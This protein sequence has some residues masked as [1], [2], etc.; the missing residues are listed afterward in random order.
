MT[1]PGTTPIRLVH[2]ALIGVL[3][4]IGG[5]ALFSFLPD[6]QNSHLFLSVGIAYLVTTVG[7]IASSL[8]RLWRGIKRNRWSEAQLEDARC[9]TCNRWYMAVLVI[10][11]VGLL[12]VILLRRFFHLRYDDFREVFYITM[13]TM[14]G[15]LNILRK[16]LTPKTKLQTERPIPSPIQSVHWGEPPATT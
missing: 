15:L 11:I 6:F 8:Y 2:F 16:P 5:E 7:L 12:V 13:F 9:F 3:I 1:F 14:S 4:F 10:A